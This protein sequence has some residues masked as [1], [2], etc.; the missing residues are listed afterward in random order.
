MQTGASVPRIQVVAA[1]LR[2]RRG[3]VLVAERPHGR[4]LAGYWE[5]PGGKLEAGETAGTAL[6]R[7]LREELGIEVCAAYRMLRFSYRYP[8]REVELDVWRVTAW[9]GEP[10]AHEGQQLAWHTPAG[11]REIRL[12]PADEPIVQ[13]L[14]LPPLLLV[15][16]PLTDEVAFLR[17]LRRSLDAGVD[18]VLFRAP[19]LGATRYTRLAGQVIQVSREAGAQVSLHGDAGLALR[20]GADGVHLGGKE[21]SAYRGHDRALRLGISCHSAKELQRAVALKADYVML[22]PVR[23]TASHPGAPALGWEQFEA[24]AAESTVPVYGIGGL[25]P[26]DLATARDHGAHGVAAIRALWDLSQ[27]SEPS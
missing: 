16:P 8:E 20:L 10:A 17:A 25:G 2:D 5:F 4:P 18:W 27:L 11:L 13:A 23:E 9:E 1:V 19:G 21:L 7:E 14:E 24:L 3:R 22:G 26:A 12:L 15:T 6:R